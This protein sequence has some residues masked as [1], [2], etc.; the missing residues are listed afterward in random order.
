MVNLLISYVLIIFKDIII[1]SYISTLFKFMAYF[2]FYMY[3]F[4]R[5]NIKDKNKEKILSNKS[6][7]LEFEKQLF[8][9]KLHNERLLNKA[10][11][12]ALTQA[13]NKTTILDIIGKSIKLEKRFSVLMYDIDNFKK[14]NDVH[15]HITGDKAIKNLAYISKRSIRDVDSLGRYGGDEFIIVLPDISHKGATYV[16]ERI[17]QNVSCDSNP[18]F[19]ISIGISS[20]PHDG[21]TVDELIQVAD[22]GLY[23]SKEK[24][25]NAVSHGGAI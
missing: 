1:F 7:K 2:Y 12:D 20:Y 10:Q 22:K 11:K 9:M 13:Y 6:S 23:M 25:K 18:R 19:T 24:G 15:G 3:F 17:R 8:H 16:A 14:I 5:I 4:K 21:R